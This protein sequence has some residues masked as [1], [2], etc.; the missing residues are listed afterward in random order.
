MWS[1]GETEE[2]KRGGPQRSWGKRPGALVRHSG[3]GPFPQITSVLRL[4]QPWESTDP[5][6]GAATA[7]WGLVGVEQGAKPQG[8]EQAPPIVAVPSRFENG[9][10]AFNGQEGRSEERKLQQ[11]I[12]ALEKEVSRKNEVIAEISQEYVQVKKGLGGP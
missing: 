1:A 12:D 4:F 2:R 6:G 8:A 7:I 10:A 11:K 3:L 5:G 9:S